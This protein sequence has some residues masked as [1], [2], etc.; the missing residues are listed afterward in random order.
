MSVGDWSREQA[1]DEY[2]KRTQGL[3]Y[4]IGERERLKALWAMVEKALQDVDAQ[5]VSKIMGLMHISPS[6]RF[7]DI[8]ALL[9]CR[10]KYN[11]Y[12]VEFGACDGVTSS[13]TWTLEKEFAWTGLLAEPALCWHDALRENRSCD[14][15]MRCV[16][17]IT[18]AMIELHEGEM[19][20]VS[21]L[22]R[23]HKFLGTVNRSYEV[24]TV[25]LGDLLEDYDAPAHIDFLSVDCEGHERQ[26]LSTLDFDKY[27]FDF[28]CVEQ[29]APIR[30]ETDVSQT[31]ERAGY[32]NLFPR[33]HDKPPH[34]QVSGPDLYFVPADSPYL[35]R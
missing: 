25:T 18:G 6:E 1:I 30:P 4:T 11:G 22:D 20:L 12:F 32:R 5:T 8:F 24:P 35:T 27:S 17:D 7:Q 2:R 29:H 33:N 13:N 34:M 31:I 16:S 23:S 19:A 26:A 21:S 14:I 9:L 15:D 28:I 3:Q 10:R